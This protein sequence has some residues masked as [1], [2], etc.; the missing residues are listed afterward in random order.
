MIWSEASVG[1]KEEQTD[2]FNLGGISSLRYQPRQAEA[3]NSGRPICEIW[4]HSRGLRFQP[5]QQRPGTRYKICPYPIKSHPGHQQPR[6]QAQRAWEVCPEARFRIGARGA[7]THSESL[8]PSLHPL[9]K[10]FLTRSHPR[11]GLILELRAEEGPGPQRSGSWVHLTE[12]RGAEGAR[13]VSRATRHC[14]RERGHYQSI[15]T[16]SSGSRGFMEGL[17]RRCSLMSQKPTQ[18]SPLGVCC[19]DADLG[20]C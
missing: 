20:L 2:H 15:E 18:A 16:S 12:K 1:G 5:G 10:E 7:R 14:S 13:V 11:P 8:I 4:S 19:E 17:P 6:S 9:R 3:R